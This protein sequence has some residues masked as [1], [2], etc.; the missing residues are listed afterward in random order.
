MERD[1]KLA[2]NPYLPLNVCIA[3]GEP[4]VFGDRIYVFG[5]HDRPCGETFCEMDYELWSAPTDDLGNWKSHG[6]IYSADQDPGRSERKPYLFAPDV[7]QGN[8]GRYYLYYSLGGWRGKHGYEGPI[9]VAVCDRPD[10]KY[11]YLGFVRNPDG[12][13]F[14]ERILFD[15]AVLN[16]DGVIRLYFGTSYFFDEHKSFPTKLLY[17]YIESKVFD[18]SF[19]QMRKAKN[20]LTGAYTVRLAD[21]MLTVISEPKLV[22]PTKTSG[23]PFAGH[24]F[25]EAASIRKLKGKYYFIY[26]SRNNHELCYAISDRP[27][28]GFTYGGTIVSNGDIGYRGRKPG[29]RLNLT[30][31]NHGSIEEIGGKTYIFYHRMTD[32]STYSRQACAEEI[33]IGQDGRIEQVEM[34]CCG[35]NGG[36]LPAQGEYP[37]AMACVVAN[38]HMP[39]LTNGKLDRKLPCITWLDGHAV[40]ADIED[41]TIVGYRSFLFS[42]GERL[43]LD[44]TGTFEGTI[45]I[46]TELGGEA[47][48]EIKAADPSQK[49]VSDPLDLN[50]IYPVYLDF[51]G[52]G[53]AT[54][55]CIDDLEEDR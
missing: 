41:G 7:A 44:M 4:H 50:G 12:T 51:R 16:D 54:L 1:M 34:S 11:E 28:E 46:L 22:V 19:A 17:Q 45:R 27:D 30:G 33:C 10:G 13:P 40:V 48:A 42:G 43:G 32:K 5:S 36:P 15:P 24:A 20:N 21:D 37:A 29:N 55:R 8:D 2:L 18:R 14:H 53:T 26:S 9:S 31:N 47:K 52:R 6:T 38:G 49:A 3:D 35:L 25:F 23:T 39:H